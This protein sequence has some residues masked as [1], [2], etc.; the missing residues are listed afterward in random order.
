MIS[1]LQKEAGSWVLPAHDLCTYL[2]RLQMKRA[3]HS[4][5]WPLSSPGQRVVDE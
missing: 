5:G 4:M 2:G 3:N 1:G